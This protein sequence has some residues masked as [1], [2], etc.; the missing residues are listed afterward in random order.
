MKGKIDWVLVPLQPLGNVGTDVFTER[1]LMRVDQGGEK[2]SNPPEPPVVSQ[3]NRVAGVST[4][5]LVEP[6]T[7]RTSSRKIYH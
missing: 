7:E 4:P 5:D 3:A 6:P 2:P 1:L